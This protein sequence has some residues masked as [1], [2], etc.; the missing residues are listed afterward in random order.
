MR[1]LGPRINGG[2]SAYHIASISAESLDSSCYL[3][4]QFRTFFIDSS[5][6]RLPI[7]FE[8]KG[9]DIGG[10]STQLSIHYPGT[11]VQKHLFSTKP[12]EFWNPYGQPRTSRVVPHCP[13]SSDTYFDP[14]SGFTRTRISFDHR[15]AETWIVG[16]RARH[17]ESCSIPKRNEFKYKWLIDCETVQLCMSD[18]PYVCLSYLW[19]KAGPGEI[20]SN[21]DL[22]AQV[23]STI[24]DA[25]KVTLAIGMRYLWVDRYC[26][27][28]ENTNEKHSLIQ[29]MDAICE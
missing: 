7:S 22:A 15:Q 19:G 8:L 5:S 3:C 11:V 16:C 4:I 1:L 9:R 27:D 20:P 17:T 21:L 26:I 2:S 18:E 10:C 6:K 14:S 13:L 25:I 12:W 29:N 24:S 28:Q 23:P